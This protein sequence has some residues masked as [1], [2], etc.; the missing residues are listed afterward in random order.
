ME[1][2]NRQAKALLRK[3]D[4]MMEMGNSKSLKT[5]HRGKRVETKYIEYVYTNNELE[6]FLNKGLKDIT[7]KD[8]MGDPF[9][10]LMVSEDSLQEWLDL[11]K[12]DNELFLN[13]YR[14]VEIVSQ[15]VYTLDEYFDNDF[16][17]TFEDLES[18]GEFS[19]IDKIILKKLYLRS[20]FVEN[21]QDKTI[22]VKAKSKLKRRTKIS[23]AKELYRLL[24]D[25]KMKEQAS[26]Y[27]DEIKAFNSKENT[28]IEHNIV[29]W[30]INFVETLWEQYAN[31][32]GNKSALKE[33]LPF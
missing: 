33:E 5:K 6:L 11:N 3:K 4:F 22:T 10:F 2:H 7:Y 1:I 24:C 23:I 32:K 15:I 26:K 30:L 8:I 25:E 28:F 31:S 20:L 9:L 29:V 17:I 27:I 13:E 19:D 14:Q 18:Y 21:K 16:V 12:V